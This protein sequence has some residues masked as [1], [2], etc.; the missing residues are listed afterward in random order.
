MTQSN[1]IPDSHESGTTS[2]QLDRYSGLSGA[3]VYALFVLGV[4]A[5]FVLI[6]SLLLGVLV[7][8]PGLAGIFLMRMLLIVVLVAVISGVS[9]Y[10]AQA[11]FQKLWELKLQRGDA[12][13][14]AGLLTGLMAVG[15]WSS[16][17]VNTGGSG[18]PIPVGEVIQ[19]QG[20]TLDGAD[21]KL[22]DQSG[23]AV[24]VDFWATWCGPCVAELPH[25]AAAYEKLHDQGLEVVGVSLDR[26]ARDLKAF[27]ADHPEP[28][29]QIYFG[30]QQANPLAEQYRIDGIP[31]LVVIG[32]DGRV[33]A[34]DVRGEEIEQ[35]CQAA[36]QG[37]PWSRA[38]WQISGVLKPLA[39]ITTAAL[40]S[41]PAT[42]ILGVLLTGILG[43]WLESRMRKPGAPAVEVPVPQ[44]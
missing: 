43:G 29:P 44:A 38:P 11:R 8:V 20:P 25:V 37:R 24:L 10:L 26:S 3:T 16:G 4:G 41:P 32:R 28:W 40:L 17:Q 2:P 23:K 13:G 1:P 22:S 31:F 12:G 15:A 42:L 18:S 14:I 35:A 33:L 30:D 9:R 27:L 34:T 39:W 21:W 6:M 7:P 5:A 36:V 19:L